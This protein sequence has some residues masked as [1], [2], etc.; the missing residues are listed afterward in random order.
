[1]SVIV[2]T[3]SCLTSEEVLTVTKK[4]VAQPEFRNGLKQYGLDEDH[5]EEFE[6][7]LYD[8]IA[9]TSAPLIELRLHHYT[10][11]LIVALARRLVCADFEDAQALEFIEHNQVY[12]KDGDLFLSR[13]MH[14]NEAKHFFECFK[15][16]SELYTLF[17]AHAI[18]KAQD[19]PEFDL[20]ERSKAATAAF[21]DQFEKRYALFNRRMI[22]IPLYFIVPIALG[23]ADD[24]NHPLVKERI[25]KRVSFLD[26]KEFTVKGYSN[27]G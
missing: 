20:H 5:P 21:V 2:F 7:E 23:E 17:K 9:K 1:M 25:Q 13:P 27:V 3:F 15:A 26:G 4:L 22:N 11:I 12:D 19:K 24:F 14:L 16:D 10:P 8:F 6:K 18:S